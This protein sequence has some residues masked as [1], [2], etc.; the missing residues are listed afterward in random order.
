MYSPKYCMFFDFHTMKACPDVGY[1]FSAEDFVGNLKN[2]GIDLIG[3]PAKCNQGFCYF[4]TRT[5]TRHPALRKDMFGDIVRACGK[6]DI[7]VNAYLNCGLSNETAI[8]HPEWC[9]V[10]PEGRLLRPDIYGIGEVTPYMRTLC[11]NSPYRDYLL[12]L[13]Q[14]VA[15]KYP[16]SG[17]LLDSF[18]G[19]PCICPHCVR[20]MKKQGIDW[21]NQEE[22]SRFG[23]MSAL[24]MAEDIS[25]MLLAVNPDFLLYFLG[26]GVKDNVRIGTYLECECLPTNP[27]WGYDYLPLQARYMRNITDGPVINMTGRFY[28]WGDFGSLRPQAAIEYDLLFGLANGMRPNIGDHMH[29]RGELNQAVFKRVKSIYDKLRQYEP[30]FENARSITEIGVV[31]P[32]AMGKSPSL[33]GVT[34]M[35]SELKMQF[36]FIDMDCDWSK[37]SV[38]I[39]PD[40]VII[41]DEI[42][43]RLNGKKIIATGSSGLNADRTSFPEN[44]G[45]RYLG[46]CDYDPAYF[47]TT[48]ENMPTAIYAKGIKIESG[49][50]TEVLGHIVKPYYNRHWDGIYSFYYTPPDQV[51]EL[52]FMTRCQDIFYCAFPLFKA[53]HQ[54]AS[55]D[56]RGV[57]EMMLS[58]LL[59]DPLLKVEL[60][61]FARAFITVSGKRQIIHLLN[62][63]PE[64]RGNALIV[65]EGIAAHEVKVSLRSKETPRKVYSAPD[66][67][68]LP[69]SVTD[70]Y[71][72]ITLPWLEGYGM[73]VV[74]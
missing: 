29:P 64:L 51:T 6:L 18:N 25:A 38:L 31:L 12:G 15:E 65:E 52:P 5:G 57:L 56:L 1:G 22:L 16:V 46:E 37:Y 7:K 17:F 2:C 54:L 14:E 4:D 68:E 10:S 70:G 9:M 48:D 63:V 32:S 24:R 30:W 36:D 69:F 50:E 60:P 20:E 33:V 21:R 35:L 3:F 74:E 67:R 11:F 49:P 40:E 39:L 41:T 23:R 34:R 27:G 73:I 44:W 8:E 45:I 42:S 19:F 72:H 47:K 13:I 58:K 59:P 26:I 28:D 66:C 71:I 62:Y 61:S 53:Y 55:V 43:F